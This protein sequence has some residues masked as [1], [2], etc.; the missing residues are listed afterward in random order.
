MCDRRS[1]EH[2]GSYQS[3]FHLGRLNRQGQ[4]SGEDSN[5][6]NNISALTGKKWRQAGKSAQ[7]FPGASLFLGHLQQGAA[8]S[9]DRPLNSVTSWWRSHHRPTP[10]GISLTCLYTPSSWQPTSAIPSL[11]VFH[12]PCVIVLWSSESRLCLWP[13]TEGCAS[14]AIFCLSGAVILFIKVSQFLQVP[15]FTVPHFHG[16][17][18]QYV[19]L[20]AYTECTLIE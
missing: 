5:C 3:S 17:R 6:R 10:R 11:W 2:R 7:L 19:K 9:E 1:R 8:H 16:N 12:R 15:E 18:W 13:A 14:A 4:M 20:I